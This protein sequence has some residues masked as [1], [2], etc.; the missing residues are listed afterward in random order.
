MP[1]KLPADINQKILGA[2]EGQPGGVRVEA[3]QERLEGLIS[4]RSLQRRLA[5]LDKEGAVQKTG[6]GKGTR[7]RLPAINGAVSIVFQPA[8]V[9]AAGEVYIP[10]SRAAEAI[11]GFV[12]KPLMERPP[13]G[14]RREFLEAYHPNDTFYLPEAV[15]NHLRHIGVTGTPGADKT[16]GT[17]ARQILDRLLVDLSWA[18]SHLEGN[19]YSLLETER[20]IA[21]GQAA[22][23]KDQS[24][25]QMI[26]NHKATIE[27]LVDAAEDIGLNRYT[28]L[29]LDALL[30]DNLLPDQASCGRLRNIPV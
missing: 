9:E 15:R 18:S 22:E 4:R 19:T 13:V 14:Y 29:N 30:S 11:R 25:T 10:I 16:A 7:Y 1:R 23:G 26:L 8:S 27:F 12:R 3:L 24:E 28:A 6:E 20:L 21:Y 2:L 17:Y 5:E